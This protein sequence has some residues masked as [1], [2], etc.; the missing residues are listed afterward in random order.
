MAWNGAV[1]S[2]STG[3]DVLSYHLMSV[4]EIEQAIDALPVQERDDLLRHLL[5]RYEDA[6][7]LREV[8][9]ARAEGGYVAWPEAKRELDAQ[10]GLHQ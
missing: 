4:T 9:A 7:D 6:L 1:V 8:E 5:A 10:F 2:C 3:R